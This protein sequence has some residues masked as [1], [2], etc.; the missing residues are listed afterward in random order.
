MSVTKIPTALVYTF[1]AYLLGAVM[2]F[3]FAAPIDCQG[4]RTDSD[5]WACVGNN[6][7]ESAV[8]GAI[9]PVF[10]AGKAVSK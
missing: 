8:D 1:G 6:I 7:V 9:W 5:L 10:W 4:S 2:T 3:N